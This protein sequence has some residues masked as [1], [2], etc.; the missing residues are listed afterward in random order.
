MSS[1]FGQIEIIEVLASHYKKSA[2][3]ACVYKSR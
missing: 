1:A 2:S 3:L